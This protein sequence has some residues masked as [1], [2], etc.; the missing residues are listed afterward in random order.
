M[1]FDRE[2]LCL[3]IRES[4]II[5][6][7]RELANEWHIFRPCRALKAHSFS[8]QLI[9]TKI[10]IAPKILFFFL[11]VATWLAKK[12]FPTFFQSN[13]LWQ[14]ENRSRTNIINDWHW[15][16]MRSETLSTLDYERITFIINRFVLLHIQKLYLEHGDNS[17]SRENFQADAESFN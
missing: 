1:R 14:I 5:N 12:I 16:W 9:S 8:T 13:M 10:C 2:I 11:V 7:K 17:Q 3:T 15:T 4:D 6:R